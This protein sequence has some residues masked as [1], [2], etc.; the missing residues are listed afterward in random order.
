MET[1][2]AIADGL[3]ILRHLTAKNLI[4][5]RIVILNRIKSAGTDT[6]PA[7]LTDVLVDMRNTTLVVDRVRTALSGAAMTLSALL[8]DHMR[9]AIVV[10][11]H[12]SRTAPA[13]HPDVLDGSA[14]SG[15]FMPF[16]MR[17]R[18]EHIRIH[19]GLSDQRRL[20]ILAVPDRH[21]HLVCPAQSV[22]DDDV[23]AG[24]DGIEAIQLRAGQMLECILTASRIER[25]AVRQKWHSAILLHNV[26]HCLRIIRSQERQVPEFPEMHL[27][28]DKL[29][30]HV[31]RSDSG[32]SNQL[33]QLCCQRYVNLRPEIGE[34][35]LCFFSH[36]S[37]L[38]FWLVSH[39]LPATFR[40]RCSAFCFP[41]VFSVRH[42]GC[43]S[44]AHSP[45]MCLDLDIN[46]F[47][48]RMFPRPSIVRHCIDTIHI[49]LRDRE[50][51]QVQVLPHPLR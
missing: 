14:E 3:R 42:A 6:A 31:N 28:G 7:A 26:S 33:L 11:L 4:R 30:S 8:L 36:L 49:D 9:L 10:L 40:I 29:S 43:A 15:C 17:Q 13:A 35:N 12:L 45:F 1:G 37:A 24:C 46:A 21:L 34:I 39:R 5:I 27:D 2:S 18:N 38:L 25:I 20:Q 47:P 41:V 50:I 23:T 19:D 51:A 48:L 22:C 44:C 32:L 16:E